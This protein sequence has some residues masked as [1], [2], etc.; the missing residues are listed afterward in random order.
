MK[1]EGKHKDMSTWPAVAGLLIGLGAG[2]YF[3]QI[4]AFALVGL[5][6]GILVA[7]SVARK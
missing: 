5:G 2:F 7:F 1:K 4:P 3:D 6:I